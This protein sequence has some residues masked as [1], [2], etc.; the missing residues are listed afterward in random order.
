[1]LFTFRSVVVPPAFVVKLVKADAPPTAPENVV[2]PVLFA[3]NPNVPFTLPNVIAPEPVSTVISVA[4]A[5]VPPMLN[6]LLAVV[7]VPFKVTLSP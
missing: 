4:R 1:M 5:V 3:V 2:A 6:A 7:Y